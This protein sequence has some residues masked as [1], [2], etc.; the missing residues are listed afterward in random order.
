MPVE[1]TPETRPAL[2]RADLERPIREACA[3][4][5]RLGGDPCSIADALCYLA[6]EVRQEH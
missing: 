1:Q 4:L 5:L 2:K 6:V 3:E